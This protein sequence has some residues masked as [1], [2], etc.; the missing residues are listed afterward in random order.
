[1]DSII[2]GVYFR[3]FLLPYKAKFAHSYKCFSA[4]KDHPS[5]QRQTQTPTEK[6]MILLSPLSNSN[7]S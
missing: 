6:L 1:M 2:E 5:L 3:Q 4:Y 7:L